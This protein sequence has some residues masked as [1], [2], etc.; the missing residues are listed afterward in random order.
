MRQKFNKKIMDLTFYEID[1]KI[2]TEHTTQQ[3]QNTHSGILQ[4]RLYVRS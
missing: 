3:Q 2:H 1:L 4:D